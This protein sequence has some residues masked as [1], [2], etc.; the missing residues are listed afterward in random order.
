MAKL[1]QNEKNQIASYK[2]ILAKEL[3]QTNAL[4]SL[5]S[6]EKDLLTD[7]LTRHLKDQRAN[8]EQRLNELYR[9]IYIV[10]GIRYR[11]TQSQNN[12]SKPLTNNIITTSGAV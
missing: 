8:Y 3:I 1:T 6:I 4:N 10:R 5:T 2:E 12:P 9:D 7:I 11:I